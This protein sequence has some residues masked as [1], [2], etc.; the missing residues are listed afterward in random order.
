MR[1]PEENHRL[2]EALHETE[3]I[4]NTALRER[5]EEVRALVLSLLSGE[6][7]YLVGPPGTG[8]SHLVR[9]AAAR[10]PGLVYVERLLHQESDRRTL[11]R[12]PLGGAGIAEGSVVFLDE[13]L[14]APK[15]LLLTLLSFMNER[16]WHDPDPKPAPLLSLFAASNSHPS[17]SDHLE[18]FFDRFALRCLV[19]PVRHFDSFAE[20]LGEGEGRFMGNGRENEFGEAFSPEDFLRLQRFVIREIPLAP[21]VMRLLWELRYRLGREGITLSDRRWKMVVKIL[22]AVACY[23]GEAMAGPRQVA[24]LLPVLW[25]YPPEIRTIRRVLWSLTEGRAGEA[26]ERVGGSLR[27]EPGD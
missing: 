25:T 11:S 16:I 3:R 7:L 17:Q 1:E 19:E 23:E 8:K 13:I 26:P 9:L 6:H 4:L 14:R 24:G 22:K 20:M 18:A 15:S 5:E 12:S 27:E 2:L 10:F 21:G